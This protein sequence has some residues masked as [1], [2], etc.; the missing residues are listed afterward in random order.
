MRDT[1]DGWSSA[2]VILY[3]FTKVGEYN[4]LLLKSRRT[5]IIK[6][7]PRTVL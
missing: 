2:V 1:D 4:Q 5:S 3:I 7:L 6:N